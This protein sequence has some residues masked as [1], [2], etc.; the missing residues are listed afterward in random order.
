[1]VPTHLLMAALMLATL[2]PLMATEEGEV[3]NGIIP[4]LRAPGLHT[5]SKES[6]KPQMLV[7]RDGDTR[8]TGSFHPRPSYK[9]PS[10][11]PGYHYHW[12][13][14]HN[15][16]FPHPDGH[17]AHRASDQMSSVSRDEENGNDDEDDDDNDEDEED[18][19]EEE[20]E[21]DD[22]EEEDDDEG[23]NDDND[24]DNDEEE[25]EEEGE[26]G[27]SVSGSTD[28]THPVNQEN[29][30]DE[31]N[32][33]G[34]GISTSQGQ[35]EIPSND[36]NPSHYGKGGEVQAHEDVN[37]DDRSMESEDFT[38]KDHPS[39]GGQETNEP[40]QVNEGEENQ[41]SPRGEMII[42]E[43]DADHEDSIKPAD[44]AGD[45]TMTAGMPLPAGST[46][47]SQGQGQGPSLVHSRSNVE[48]GGLRGGRVTG[49]DPSILSLPD[50]K[51]RPVLENPGIKVIPF[52]FQ[53]GNRG[54]LPPGHPTPKELSAF[55][56][57]GAKDPLSL[58]VPGGRGGGPFS[59]MTSAPNSNS[60]TGNKGST[61]PVASPVVPASANLVAGTPQ[62]RTELLPQEK[63]LKPQ[64]IGNVRSSAVD[65][66]GP[67]H[68]SSM[69]STN[70]PST[71]QTGPGSMPAPAIAGVVLGGVLVAVGALALLMVR[72]GKREDGLN[73]KEGLGGEKGL[74]GQGE[75]KGKG[76][77]GEE[78]GD[79][80]DDDDD[81][82]YITSMEPK[83]QEELDREM[84]PQPMVLRDMSLPRPQVGEDQGVVWAPVMPQMA[85]VRVSA[86]PSLDIQNRRESNIFG[87]MEEGE[88]DEE[89]GK[90][91]MNGGGVGDEAQEE[92]GHDMSDQGIQM[93]DEGGYFVP[94]EYETEGTG[95]PGMMMGMEEEGHH[96]QGDGMRMEDQ[97]TFEAMPIGYEEEGGEGDHGHGEGMEEA[98]DGHRMTPMKEGVHGMMEV[99]DGEEHGVDSED[100]EHQF[101]RPPSTSW[102][103]GEAQADRYI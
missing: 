9:A 32:H 17:V 24:E 50:G 47:A 76:H 23:A 28:L 54:I 55:G 102:N 46:L 38:E 73:I 88:E 35:K 5:R 48:D 4:P 31:A 67:G 93:E 21:D 72:T 101:P 29:H 8:S 78:K 85:H 39:H 75:N 96:E 18:G 61:G 42:A 22:E 11:G 53:A 1:M 82:G 100:V 16:W 103:H 64:H 27:I 84:M 12:H 13:P 33:E 43:H 68:Y 69:T 34:G 30:A 62:P 51:D 44:F 52:P 6:D 40:I 98:R 70:A 90:R 66:D 3:E 15:H 56:R 59:T 74:D 26:E 25:E 94:E 45:G 7:R 86:V 49:K 36:A 57:T 92:Y 19:D 10:S 63:S 14:H 37:N 81:G 20:E 95:S 87:R 83:T 2:D 41:S 77:H 89:D 97:V 58:G 91:G 60:L 99:R 65:G 79:D 71:A 80:D